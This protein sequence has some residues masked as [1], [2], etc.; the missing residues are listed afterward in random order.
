LVKIRKTKISTDDEGYLAGLISVAVPVLGAN[1]RMIATVAVHAPTA[2][3]SLSRA[4]AH[5]GLLKR[6][7][8]DLGRIYRQF[9]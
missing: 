5:V 8:S 4:L 1:R 6:A 9:K 7:A 3:M 2:R